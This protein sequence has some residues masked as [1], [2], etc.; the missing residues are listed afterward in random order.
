MT[1][2]HRA[3]EV[4]LQ[5][6]YRY[7]AINPSELP[8]GAA[9]A[10]DIRKHFD[11]FQTPDGLREFAALLI[12]GTLQDLKSLDELI[13]SHASN[14]KLSRMPLIDRML[15][16]MSTYELTRLTETPASVVINEAIE[17]AKQFGTA[18][19]PAFVNGVLDGIRRSRKQD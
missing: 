3:R 18:E 6:L 11:H 17:L 1:T 9:L 7:D 8:T 2:R 5:V 15:L 4:A 16:R 13:E 12:A 10:A 14:W 19:T